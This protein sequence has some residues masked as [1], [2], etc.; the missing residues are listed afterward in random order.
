MIDDFCKSTG[1]NTNIDTCF[2][3]ILLFILFHA[4][5]KC[6]L[7]CWHQISKNRTST[8]V[9][10]TIINN[11]NVFHDFFW[12]RFNLKHIMKSTKINENREICNNIEQQTQKNGMENIMFRL[13]NHNP[14]LS[15]FLTYHI[16]V[17]KVTRSV[18]L[19]E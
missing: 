13:S 19:V 1:S 3:C 10:N 2:F 9:Y 11:N 14:V 4:A 5:N 15:S 17:I 18:L 7:Q 12:S 8:F 16:F 6:W